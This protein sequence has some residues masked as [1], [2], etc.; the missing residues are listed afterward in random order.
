M[1]DKPGLVC[2]RRCSGLLAAEI[3][4]SKLEA[5]GIPVLLSY[6]SAGPVIGLTLDGLGEVA[7]LVPTDLAEDAQSLLE[8]EAAPGEDEETP[9]PSSAGLPML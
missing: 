9:L 7:I 5:W 8:E 3:Y 6:E 4:R 1:E 2:V